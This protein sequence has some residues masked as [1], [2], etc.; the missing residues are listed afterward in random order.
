G[1]T[2][3]G[4]QRVP[5]MIRWPGKIPSHTVSDELVASPDIYRTFLEL[6]GA[7]LPD[8]PIDGF[9]IMPF[10]LG[11]ADRSPRKEYAYFRNTLEAMRIGEWKLR[12][13]SGE[14]ELFNLQE[15]P[16]E[17]YNRASDNPE[18]VN[19]I[20]KRMEEFADE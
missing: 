19:E 4:G 15:D 3:E 18:L 10:L 16:G 13:A 20:R 11:Q 2:Y 1:T 5:A 7:T 8:H 6:A 14:P 9:D 12:L 17:R